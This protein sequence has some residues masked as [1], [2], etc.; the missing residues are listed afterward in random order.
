MKVFVFYNM[1][2]RLI[3]IIDILYYYDISDDMYKIK[4]IKINHKHSNLICNNIHMTLTKII[5]LL[6]YSDFYDDMYKI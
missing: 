2:M 3:K 4:F 1:H 5:D 6:Y